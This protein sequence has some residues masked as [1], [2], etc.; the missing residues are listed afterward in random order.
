M[1]SSD[2][3][4]TTAL[5]MKKIRKCFCGNRMS[6]L[7]YDFHTVGCVLHGVLVCV[8]LMQGVRN[9]YMEPYVKHQNL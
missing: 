1:T 8:T 2:S 6:S 7:I 9:D 5:Q 4:A 3:S